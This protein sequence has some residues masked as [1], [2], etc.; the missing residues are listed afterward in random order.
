MVE[1]IYQTIHVE[2]IWV[3]KRIG[4]AKK[5]LMYILF[6]WSICRTCKYISKLDYHDK[7]ASNSYSLNFIYIISWH[8]SSKWLARLL[9]SEVDAI[10]DELT[11]LKEC[12]KPLTKL[13]FEDLHKYVN[14]IRRRFLIGWLQL[15][16]FFILI[17][18]KT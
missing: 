12:Q 1:E 4:S 7:R 17:R 2:P 5:P 13:G 18:K 15:H 16:Y 11:G 8:A 6:F 14:V 3:H 10:E 9:I